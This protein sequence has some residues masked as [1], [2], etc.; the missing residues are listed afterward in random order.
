M[1]SLMGKM[2]NLLVWAVGCYAGGKESFKNKGDITA[3]PVAANPVFPAMR[4]LSGQS[5]THQARHS[6]ASHRGMSRLAGRHRARGVL[7]LIIDGPIGISVCTR[8]GHS[9]HH[10]RLLSVPFGISVC[11]RNGHSLH[12]MRLLS[13]PYQPSAIAA[14]KVVKL[15]NSPPTQAPVGM[16]TVEGKGGWS[17]KVFLLPSGALQALY[18]LINILFVGLCAAWLG[19]GGFSRTGA[20][21]YLL[22]V[23]ALRPNLSRLL[24]TAFPCPF[25]SPACL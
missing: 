20:H 19:P 6:S 10:R 2:L 4:L 24:C 21:A 13:V 11:T 15:A 18:S 3:V 9:L 25:T 14:F 17:A 8:N 1:H 16:V 22:P 23:I 7:C 5:H 12:N